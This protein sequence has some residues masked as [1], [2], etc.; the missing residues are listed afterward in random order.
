MVTYEWED[1]DIKILNLYVMCPKKV[2]SRFSPK[3]LKKLKNNLKEELLK[4]QKQENKRQEEDKIKK[5]KHLESLA[6]HEKET[7]YIHD[8]DEPNGGVYNNF[9]RQKLEGLLYATTSNNAKN[10]IV[11][12]FIK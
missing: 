6:Y 10:A 1:D 5:Q 12:I 2:K 9:E 7:I 11:A 8:E 4:G 3:Y